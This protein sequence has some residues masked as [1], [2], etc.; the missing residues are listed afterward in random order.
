[1]KTRA[2]PEVYVAIFLHISVPKGPTQLELLQ[3]ILWKLQA[4]FRLI[5]MFN[6]LEVMSTMDLVYNVFIVSNACVLEFSNTLRPMAFAVTPWKYNLL[7]VS[8]EL[9][10]KLIPFFKPR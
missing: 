7:I 10:V 4:D 2:V 1:M 3:P 6:Q 9:R 8:V 5:L